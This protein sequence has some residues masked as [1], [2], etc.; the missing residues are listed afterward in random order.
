MLGGASR[1][2]THCF[3]GDKNGFERMPALYLLPDCKHHHRRCPPKTLSFLP[4]AAA[5][6]FQSF[7]Q[8]F[9]FSLRLFFFQ[10]IWEI[11]NMQ[12]VT[13]YSL[14]NFTQLGYS[15]LILRLSI[16][17]I[18]NYSFCAVLLCTP[19]GKW[20][21][22]I[23]LKIKALWP[24]KVV[25]IYSISESNLSWTQRSKWVSFSFDSQSLTGIQSD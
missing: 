15:S 24:I 6:Q 25:I 13:K 2:A 7:L 22:L 8:M 16:L 18:R 23:R 11:Q 3:F 10:L 5:Q 19:I 1:F 4:A 21:K 14:C 17:Q 12:R 20:Q 9:K